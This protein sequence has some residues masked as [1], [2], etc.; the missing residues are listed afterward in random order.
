MTR[1]SVNS[2]AAIEAIIANWEEVIAEI[3]AEEMIQSMVA[4]IRH[5]LDLSVEDFDADMGKIMG[6]ESLDGHEYEW[7][8]IVN[9]AAGRYLVRV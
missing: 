1:F 6:W 4:Q 2:E 7:A 9:T 3:G 5:E 8:E